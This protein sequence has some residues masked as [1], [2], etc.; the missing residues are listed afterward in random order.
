M[1]TAARDRGRALLSWKTRALKFQSPC[2]REA[3]GQY[4]ITSARHLIAPSAFNHF[5]VLLR[6]V[7][8][9]TLKD[10]NEI[11]SKPDKSPSPLMTSGI[12][13]VCLKTSMWNASSP[14][15]LPRERL[16]QKI[17]GL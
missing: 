15:R 5:L 4:T 12:L 13:A 17:H 14:P 3:D 6:K 10:R 9:A 7:F 11:F 8:D 2:S 1:Q 16:A